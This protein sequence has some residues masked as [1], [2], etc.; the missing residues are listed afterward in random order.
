MSRILAVGDIHGC[1]TALDTLLGFI[2]PMPEDQLVF[3]GDYI[4]RGPDSKGVLDR[5]IE[6]HSR[7]NVICIRGNHEIMMQAGREGRDDFRYWMSFGGIEL[8]ES[9]A[10]LDGRISLDNIPDAHWQ[11]VGK[12]CVD[13]HETETHI[14]V[15]AG[16][17]PDLPLDRQPTEWLHWQALSA[18]WHQ[19]HVSGKTV[20]CGHT[21]QRDGIPLQLM[22]AICIDTAAYNNGW[23]TCLDVVTSEYWQA[24]EFGQTR[25]GVL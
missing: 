17:H 24:N 15:H 25:E 6:L 22:R 8:L 16:L 21:Q 4:D 12:T 10:P 5:L 14:F 1:L 9:Y 20:I 19:P 18:Q 2:N 3:L 7:G 23:L 13:W 11:F